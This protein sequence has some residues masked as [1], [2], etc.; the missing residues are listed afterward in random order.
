MTSLFQQNRLD[1][2]S[3]DPFRFDGQAG[4]VNIATSSLAVTA[5]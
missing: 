3:I 1:S 4:L 5:L 2:H